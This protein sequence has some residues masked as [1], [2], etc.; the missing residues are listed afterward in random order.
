MAQCTCR[1]VTWSV[2]TSM[3]Q[4]TCH[5]RS[6]DMSL[7]EYS[8]ECILIQCMSCCSCTGWSDT[9]IRNVRQRSYY[10]EWFCTWSVFAVTWLGGDDLECVLLSVCVCGLLK[11]YF[12]GC[13]LAEPVLL[14]KVFYPAPATH[15]DLTVTMSPVWGRG[16]PLPP[17]PFTPFSLTESINQSVAMKDV[18][19]VCLLDH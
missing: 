3:W 13:N 19:T 15:V 5:Q 2:T 18:Y 9:D 12:L 6:G 17:C 4:V 8:C 1:S 14:K 7:A 16:T 10:R 11:C